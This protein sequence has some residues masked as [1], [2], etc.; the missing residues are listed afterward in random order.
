M[1]TLSRSW[2]LLGQSFTVLKSDEELMWL[3]I[4]SLLFCLAAIVTIGA[5]GLLFVL[6]PGTV[7]HDAA[8]QRLIGRGM[9]PFIFLI[10]V[11]TYSLT[12]YFNV[13]LVSIASNRLAGGHATLNDGLQ[14]AW[15][16]R[17][18]IF[19]WALFAAT[20]GII[21]GMIERRLSYLGR[22]IARVTGL[23]WTLASFFV[24][25]LLVVEDMGP[26]EAMYESAQIVRKRWGEE[27]VGGFSFQGVFFLLALPGLL[28]PLM[29]AQLGQIGLVAGV[30]IAAIY[31]MLLGIASSTAQGIFVAA[32]FRYATNQQVVGGY[33][34]ESFSGAWKPKVR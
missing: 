3:P 4:L 11:V 23:V 28:L 14:V 18:S 8:Q 7:P 34:L 16:R 17:W 24:V 2:D 15:K 13:A 31:W 27:V 10:Y 25:P 26:V 22:F 6:P 12:T 21:L 9:E 19:Q 32:L 5:T 30:A 20:V 33:D 29:G 1:D